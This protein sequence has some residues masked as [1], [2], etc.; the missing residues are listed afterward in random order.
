MER[1]VGWGKGKEMN[2]RDFLKIVGVGTSAAVVGGEIVNA[3]AAPDLPP[4][5]QASAA[6]T[7]DPVVHVLNRITFGPRPG[8]VD[9][10]KK[11]GVQAF[12]EQQLNPQ[13]I[14]DDAVQQRLGNYITLDMTPAELLNY[15]KMERQPIVELDS[16]TVV[17]AT[18]SER[19]LYEIMVDFWSEHFSIWH[20][21]EQDKLFNTVDD[22][23]V[24]RK[25][26]LGKFRDILRASDK[27]A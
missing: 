27:S 24:L 16:A 4:S 8:Q 14:N 18:Y 3:L 21:K 13:T 19:Q 6:A 25:Y 22:R 17:R 11:I 15:A 7:V 2:G 20:Q 26:A 23:E 1:G 12:L 10:V 5:L 9:A